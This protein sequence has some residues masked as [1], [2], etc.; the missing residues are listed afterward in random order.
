MR[1]RIDNV[2][3]GIKKDFKIDMLKIRSRAIRG[4]C[5]YIKFDDWKWINEALSR[6][7]SDNLKYILGNMKIEKEGE[8]ACLFY[9]K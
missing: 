3:D 6:Y 1:N 9:K 8:M 4:K 7:P 5:T 2:I